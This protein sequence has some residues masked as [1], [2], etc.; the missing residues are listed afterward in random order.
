MGW[1]GETIKNES[2]NYR[3]N[4]L[5]AIKSPEKTGNIYKGLNKYFDYNSNKSSRNMVGMLSTIISLDERI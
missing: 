5:F 2:N 3:I 4:K 1:Y